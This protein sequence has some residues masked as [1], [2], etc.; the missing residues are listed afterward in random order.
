MTKNPGPDP[1]K[2]NRLLEFLKRTPERYAIYQP[3]TIRILLEQGKEN[4]FSMEESK[5]VSKIKSLTLHRQ[6]NRTDLRANLESLT[7]VKDYTWHSDL[8]FFD[9]EHD[10]PIWKLNPDEFDEFQ[11]EEILKECNKEIV[12]FHVKNLI[13]KN[14]TPDVYF[15]RAGKD[16][17]WYDEFL[18]NTQDSE[19][20]LDWETAGINYGGDTN[21]DLNSKSDDDIGNLPNYS[22]RL[23]WFKNIK[24]GDIVAIKKIT[25]M[26]L[27]TLELLQ[28]NTSLMKVQHHTIIES[29]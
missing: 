10:P 11:T 26:E 14:L 3:Y 20:S 25:Q 8:V 16:G 21:F 15:I 29:E 13:E 27:P 5:I 22:I 24:K 7:S 2:G 9:D 6:T 17:T 28:K 23:L 18:K 12:K 1:D 19:S 4:D